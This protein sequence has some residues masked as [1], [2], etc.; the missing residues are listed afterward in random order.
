MIDLHDAHRVNLTVI[1]RSTDQEVTEY[2]HS[3]FQKAP[4]WNQYKTFSSE[5]EWPHVPDEAREKH[6]CLMLHTPIYQDVH[7]ICLSILYS[8]H[9][10]SFFASILYICFSLKKVHDESFIGG[11]LGAIRPIVQAC[12]QLL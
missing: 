3:I 8:L 10:S 9:L 4:W 1:N 11:Y 6:F 2:I 12:K 7:F 5:Y